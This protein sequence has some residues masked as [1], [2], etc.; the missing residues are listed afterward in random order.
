MYAT[1]T[2]DQPLKMAITNSIITGPLLCLGFWGSAL[3]PAVDPGG[4]QPPNIF[5]CIL[6]I[7]LHLFDCLP[8]ND[9]L[10]YSPL[11]E[12]GNCWELYIPIGPFI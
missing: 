6:G 3:A 8:K 7:N 9:D 11:N 12:C 2:H 10:V 1:V 5:W 4:A